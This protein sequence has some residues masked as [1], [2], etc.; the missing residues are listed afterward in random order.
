MTDEYKDF[1][2]AYG[3]SIKVVENQKPP[4]FIKS[5]L[6]LGFLPKNL[7]EIKPKVGAHFIL[8]KC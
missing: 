5:H 2:V 4:R 7:K 1:M 8:I 3:N 6:P